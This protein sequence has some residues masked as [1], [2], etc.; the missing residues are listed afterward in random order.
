MWDLT[1]PKCLNYCSDLGFTLAGVEN[2]AE[3]YCANSLSTSSG[4][5]KQVSEGDCS[6]NCAGDNGTK[7]GGFWRLSL[8]STL[9]GS[10]LSSALTQ[11]VTTTSTT[12]AATVQPTVVPT[13]TTTAQP[14]T[15]TTTT[16]V[17]TPTASP[18]PP[19]APPAQPSSYTIPTNFP[20]GGGD[21][22][23]YAHFIVGNSYPYS[24]DTWRTDIGR[25]QAAGLDGFV[26]NL[27]PDAWQPSRVADAYY[28]AAEEGFKMVLSFDMYEFDCGGWDRYVILRARK[29]LS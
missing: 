18:S 6:T 25:A 23:I 28:V 27:G 15:P 21:K 24:V 14:V 9:S 12:T 17:P 10:A 20:S 5:G 29:A 2:E 1:I 3:C 16:D 8:Y 19:P 11:P 7:C 22:Q 13:T 26:L 4:Q